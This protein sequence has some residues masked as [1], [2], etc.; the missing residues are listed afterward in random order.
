MWPA[1]RTHFISPTELEAHPGRVQQATN[2]LRTV[3]TARLRVA[4]QP[5][6]LRAARL[7]AVATRL[8]CTAAQVAIAWTL[9]QSP[10]NL[11]IAGTSSVAHLRENMD[12]LAVDVDD[13]ALDQLARAPRPVGG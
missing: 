1:C 12:A 8:G 5:R 13:A 6:E 3:R 4:R 10:R 7:S 2:R 9:V 11:V